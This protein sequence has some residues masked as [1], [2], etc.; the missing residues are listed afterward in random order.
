MILLGGSDI[1][2]LRSCFA[3]DALG[4]VID[5]LTDRDLKPPGWELGRFAALV[6]GLPFGAPVLDA[7][8]D[9]GRC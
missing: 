9:T 4:C 7:D 5:R 2:G 8:L 1:D 6:E 3:V